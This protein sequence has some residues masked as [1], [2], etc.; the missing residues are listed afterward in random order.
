MTALLLACMMLFVGC[1]PTEKESASSVMETALETVESQLET[2]ETITETTDSVIESSAETAAPAV[3][4]NQEET[5]T[6]VGFD[7]PELLQYVEDSIYAELEMQLDSDAY[8][9]E[10]ITT[11]YVSQEYLDEVAYNSKSNVYFGYTVTELDEFFQGT[12]YVFALDENGQTIVQ[13]MQMVDDSATGEIIK[14]VAIGTGLI[15][16]CVTVSYFTG[17]TATPTAVNLFFT[18]AAKTGT[19]F[20]LSSGA[21]GGISAGIVKGIETGDM[22]E[23]LE[24]AALVGSESF[25]WGAIT[26]VLTGGTSKA[27]SIYR[28]TKVVPTPRESE[29]KVL[30]MMDD[31]I[32]Q[33][34]YLDGKQVS[35][36]TLN[37]TRP[38]VV[39]QNANG[40]VHAVEVK[41]YSLDSTASRNG[42][43]KTLE[44]QITARTQHLPTGST[45][46]IVLDVRGRG[47]T[48]ELIESVITSIKDR[49]NG[50]YYDIPVTVLRY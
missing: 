22:N 49:L 24:A 37:S 32:E 40:T 25:K 33:A 1:I 43:L 30:D 50:V 28:S 48:T 36:T 2:T 38:D 45:Q 44:H 13:E 15:L 47:Y 6:F 26:G 11:S 16:V 3:I 21:I 35:S 23:A 14:N 17:G 8:L 42:L 31:A 20:A 7:D 46:E 39:I 12:R 10:N 4:V 9:I 18:A 34:A 41:N 5:P 29:I 27:L 19:T